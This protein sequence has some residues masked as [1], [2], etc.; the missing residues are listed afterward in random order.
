MSDEINIDGLSRHHRD[1]AL[2]EIDRLGR[3][4]AR[5]KQMLELV[6]KQPPPE[7]NNL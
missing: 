3:E 1:K 4:L 7:G 2:E 6:K 5:L